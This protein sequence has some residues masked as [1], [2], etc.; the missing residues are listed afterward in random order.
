[1]PK[2]TAGR[3]SMKRSVRTKAPAA[4][5]SIA[6]APAPKTPRAAGRTEPETLIYP[7]RIKALLKS[8]G[9]RCSPDFLD[10]L[11]ARV[12]AMIDASAERAAANRR[13][14]ARAQDA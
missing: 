7:G 5:T 10:A 1:M 9:L 12:H 11:N 6:K 3:E 8:R 14:T 4:K 2:K 13:S